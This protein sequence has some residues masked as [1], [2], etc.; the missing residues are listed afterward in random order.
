MGSVKPREETRDFGRTQSAKEPSSFGAASLSVMEKSPDFKPKDELSSRMSDE[1]QK[2]IA[3]Y[4]S[5]QV[6]FASESK[7]KNAA[8]QKEE[9]T[10]KKPVT[11]VMV[12]AGEELTAV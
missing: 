6:V 2:A 8:P 1:Y 3:F 7:E 5:E 10:P 4:A 9:S 12:S 11:K